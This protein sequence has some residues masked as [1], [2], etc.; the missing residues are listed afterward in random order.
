MNSEFNHG[1]TYYPNGVSIDGHLFSNKKKE[2]WK[3]MNNY[4]T[5]L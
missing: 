4:L 1:F 5:N 2:W 3:N